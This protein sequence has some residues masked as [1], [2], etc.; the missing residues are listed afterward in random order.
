MMRWNKT[1]KNA[2]ATGSTFPSRAFI[3]LRRLGSLVG[4]VDALDVGR[5]RP[6]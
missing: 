4:V 5:E 3:S 1:S 6:D 2:V